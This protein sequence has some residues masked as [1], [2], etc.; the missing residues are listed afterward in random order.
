M[1]I[2]FMPKVFASLSSMTSIDPKLLTLTGVPNVKALE[3][4]PKALPSEQR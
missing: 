1:E 4:T 2:A 3:E